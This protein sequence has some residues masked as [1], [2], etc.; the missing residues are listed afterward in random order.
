MESPMQLNV[1]LMTG[2]HFEAWQYMSVEWTAYRYAE[3]V[4]HCKKHPIR[5]YSTLFNQFHD[6]ILEIWNFIIRPALQTRDHYE[7][8]SNCDSSTV[9]W[10]A[11]TVGMGVHRILSRSGQTLGLGTKFPAKSYLK[12]MHKYFIY[13]D[14]RQHL[15][16]KKHF[17]TFPGRG[18]GTN[19]P[20]AHACEHPC[21]RNQVN[22]SLWKLGVLCSNVHFMC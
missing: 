13:W 21:L 15:R 10:H 3:P 16:H 8:E 18:G 2:A 9:R 22:T 17:T 5:E 6:H 19:A 12:I 11:F 14:F 7:F 20:L 1:C 4:W